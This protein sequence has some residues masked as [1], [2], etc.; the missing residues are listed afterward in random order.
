MPI[1]R[2][3]DEMIFDRIAQR[4]AGREIEA[5]RHRGELLLMR[6]RERRG[7][8]GHLGEGAKA[9]PASPM[10][11]ARSSLSGWMF[12]ALEVGSGWLGMFAGT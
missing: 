2:S 4:R 10:R 8:A 1:T 12:C 6:D 7:G 5:E 11:R 3:A 9:A